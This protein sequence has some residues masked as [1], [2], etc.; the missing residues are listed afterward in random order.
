MV[1]HPRGHEDLVDVL[2]GAAALEARVVL[3]QGEVIGTNWV[4]LA[5]G[6]G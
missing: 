2:V 6:Q 5:I 4:V 1:C 3:A